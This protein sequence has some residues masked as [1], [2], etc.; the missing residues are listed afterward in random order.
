MWDSCVPVNGTFRTIPTVGNL[1]WEF[2]ILAGTLIAVK[3][4]IV[5]LLINKGLRKIHSNKSGTG[6]VYF[7]RLA[8]VGINIDFSGFAMWKYSYVQHA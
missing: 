8:T 4:L 5:K 2:F 6:L 1:W 3:L 7:G